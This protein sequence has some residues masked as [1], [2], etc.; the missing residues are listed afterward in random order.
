MKNL[1]FIGGIH[2]VGK[3]TL[4][5]KLSSSSKLIH[6]ASSDLIK[7]SEISSVKNKT[8]N[9]VLNTQE[10]LISGLEKQIIEDKKYLLDGH[11]CLLNSKNIPVVVPF[12]T[13]KRINPKGI[14]LVTE[15]IKLI[16]QRL[17]N[18]D[19]VFYSQELL[20]N[21]QNREK[22]Q[23]KKTAEK[24]NIRLLYYNNNFEEA[25]NFIDNL[26]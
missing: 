8:V 24:L 11:F 18:R 15:K 22:E 7:W 20:E 10:R 4:C 2:G 14:I 6:L 9:N 13:F 5:K 26:L 1:I 16:S 3:G 23:A 25:L 17:N 21:F 19:N 12:E